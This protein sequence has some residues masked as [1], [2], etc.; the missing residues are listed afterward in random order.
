MPGMEGNIVYRDSSIGFRG[1]IN[2][3]SSL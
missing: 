2:I 1:A 3:T